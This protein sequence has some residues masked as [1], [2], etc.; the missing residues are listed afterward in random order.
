MGWGKKKV[1]HTVCWGFNSHNT[2]GRKAWPPPFL[3][4][5]EV[6]PREDKQV[7]ERGFR[8]IILPLDCTLF[9]LGLLP[10]LLFGFVFFFSTRHFQFWG[11]ALVQIGSQPLAD[12]WWVVPCSLF[13]VAPKLRRRGTLTSLSCYTAFPPP[14]TWGTPGQTWGAASVLSFLRL[15]PPFLCAGIGCICRLPCGH[16]VFSVLSYS[17]VF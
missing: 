7:V 9:F 3:L 15:S 8:L 4:K 14:R 6:I 1:P 17:F 13:L 11:K 5:K 10:S 16:T 2:P 12:Q